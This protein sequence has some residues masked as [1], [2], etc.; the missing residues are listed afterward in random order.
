MNLNVKNKIGARRTIKLPTLEDAN[1]V[2]ATLAEI[3]RLLA[4]NQIEQRAATLMLYALQIAS[5][6]LRMTSLEPHQGYDP[7]FRHEN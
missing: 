6:N 1:S 3:M 2:H 4:T 5:A 7:D